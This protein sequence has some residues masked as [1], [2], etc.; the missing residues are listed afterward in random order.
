MVEFSIA[1]FDYRRV[2]LTNVI[3]HD[4]V[5]L[6][7]PLG[8]VITIRSGLT[9]LKFDDFD[10]CKKGLVASSPPQHWHFLWMDQKGH[11]EL[12]FS[13]SFSR[14]FPRLEALQVAP[15]GAAECGGWNGWDGWYD[16]CE[17]ESKIVLSSKSTYFFNGIQWSTLSTLQ[18]HW[19]VHH[20]PWGQPSI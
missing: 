5:G 12:G 10:D 11:S 17:G 2:V 18:A 13:L 3:S 14:A 4:Q 6:M 7:S 20:E 1:I 8:N 16:G 9:S 19:C 15:D